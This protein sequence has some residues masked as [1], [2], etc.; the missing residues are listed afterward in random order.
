MPPR[1]RLCPVRTV[2]PGSSSWSVPSCPS[3]GGRH[4]CFGSVL[5]HPLGSFQSQNGVSRPV[6]P[7]GGRIRSPCRRI[8]APASC[9]DPLPGFRPPSIP[10]DRYTIA[11]RYQTAYD[12]LQVPEAFLKSH[13]PGFRGFVQQC[14]CGGYAPQ[15]PLN[16]YVQVLNAAHR[17]VGEKSQFRR[18]GPYQLSRPRERSS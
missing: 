18:R 14:L 8:P 13:T 4:D 12:P 1:S 17:D 7:P 16:R 6:Y 10:A 2:R 15:N 5:T 9:F 3:E 11:P